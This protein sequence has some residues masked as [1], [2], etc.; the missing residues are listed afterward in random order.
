[1]AQLIKVD[2]SREE[3]KPANPP[4]LSLGEMQLAIQGFIELAPEISYS[5]EAQGKLMFVDEEGLFNQKQLNPIATLL[6]GRH[7]VGDALL[8]DPSEVES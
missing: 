3:V 7:I 4:Y 5:K 8:C 6:A 2:G 1:M